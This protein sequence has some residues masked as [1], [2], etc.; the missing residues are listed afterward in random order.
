MQNVT[1]KPEAFPN[2]LGK[3]QS[4]GKNQRFFPKMLGICE[5]N[6][7]ASPFSVA[8]LVFCEPIG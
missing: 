6:S 4:Y 8:F 3:G 7:V 1:E 5:A 2:M